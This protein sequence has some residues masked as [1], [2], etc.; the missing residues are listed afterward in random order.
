MSTR[1]AS[2]PLDPARL[3]DWYAVPPE[4]EGGTWVRGGFIATLD[5]RVTGAD[6]LSGGLNA[7]SS[8]DHAVFDH[9]RRWADAVVVGA[10]TV[11]AE[12]YGPL[13]GTNL[14]VV[15]RD[16]DV[17]E[18]VRRRGPGDGQVV[19]LGGEGTP[20]TPGAVLAEVGARGWRNVVL[21]GGP[22]LFAQWV[23]AGVVDELCL[24]LRP[25]LAGGDGPLLVP[26]DVEFG[27]LLGSATHVL[28][29]DGDIL[30]RARLR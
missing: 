15:T 14:V 26:Q 17:P 22:R 27:D 12:S 30:V 29:W 13:S 4:A 11:R 21:E 10:G 19:V 6:G 8:G 28:T 3:A 7:G 18:K 5:G 9:L 25:V 20:V 24:T 16:G 23:R 1:A 2:G